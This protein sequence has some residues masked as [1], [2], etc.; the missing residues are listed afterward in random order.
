M[1]MLMQNAFYNLASF[2][3]ELEG[4]R[5]ILWPSQ[6][7]YCRVSSSLILIEIWDLLCG[8]ILLFQVR[9]ARGCEKQIQT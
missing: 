6:I 7:K 1:Q 5:G 4:P 8:H 3:W 2:N 9:Q